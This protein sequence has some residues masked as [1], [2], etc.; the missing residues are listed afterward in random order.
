MAS[1]GK[2]NGNPPHELQTRERNGYQEFW[3]H[4]T[5][6]WEPTH[7]R[8][9]AKRLGDAALSG[10]QVHHIDGDKQNNRPSNLVALTPRMHGRVESTPDACYICGRVGHWA[11]DCYAKTDYKGT[12]IR[13]R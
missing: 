9:M 4:R 2:H 10:L 7:R 13:N 12:R 1:N 5:G 8:V 6:R 3:D 11:Q